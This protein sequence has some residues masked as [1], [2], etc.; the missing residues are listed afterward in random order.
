MHIGLHP[1]EILT[2][3]REDDHGRH[4]IWRE[5]K[6]VESVDGHNRLEE[7]REGGTKA[8]DKVTTEESI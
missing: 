8:A 2:Q 4:C 7:I 6:E 1:D 3:M 5:I